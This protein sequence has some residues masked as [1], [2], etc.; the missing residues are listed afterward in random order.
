M[1]KLLGNLKVSLKLTLISVAFVI[2]ILVLLYFLTAEQN[3]RIDFAQKEIYGDEYLRPLKGLMELAPDYKH[4]NHNQSNGTTNSSDAKQVESKIDNLFAE[5]EN[6]ETKL[7]ESLSTKEKLEELKSVWASLK[8]NPGDS[9]KGKEFISGIRGMISYVGDKSNLILDP[10]LDSYYIMD[11][12]LLKLPENMD[13]LYQI[14]TYGNDIVLKGNLTPEEK[15]ELIVKTGLLKSN[16]EALT[17]GVNVAFDNNPAENLKGSLADGLT[18][19][20]NGVNSFLRLVNKKILY[21]DTIAVSSI[22]Y[23]AAAKEALKANFDFWDAAAADLD[24][25]LQARIDG[26]NS[27]KYFTLG[28]VAIVLVLSLGFVFFITKN[29]TTSILTLAN[30]AKQFSEG[31]NNIKVEIDSKDELGMLASVF[32]EMIVKINESIQTVRKEKEDVEKKIEI[33]VKESEEK[34]IYLAESVDTMLKSIERFADGDLSVQLNVLTNDDIGKLYNGFNKAVISIKEL[35]Y[36]LTDTINATTNVASQLSSSTGDLAAGFEEQ[37]NQTSEVA[38][39]ISEMTSTIYDTTKNAN[40]AA[41]AANKAGDFAKEGGTVVKETVEGMNRIAQVVTNASQTVDGLGKSSDQIGE[42]IQVIDDIADQTN[43]LALNAA[44][45]AARAGEQGRG[46][47]VVADEV[48]KLAE[49][50]TK[51]TKEIAGMIKQIQ[52]ETKVAVASIAAGKTEVERGKELAAKA[53]VALQEIIKASDEVLGVINQ[54]AAASEE[55][56][57]AAEQINNNIVNISKVVNDSAMNMN[58]IVKASESLND[59]NINLK[60]LISSFS[61]SKDEVLAA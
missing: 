26:F 54:V 24:E 14:L 29:I 60:E 43:L 13:L 17:T 38:S 56:S 32:N 5:I 20:N 15:T 48:R 36:S 45:E 58:H 34:N 59:L 37:G 55:Q 16:S 31:E 50:T 6:T 51:A 9:E 21:T 44:I 25:L 33:A 2:P 41:K 3:I 39:A 22:E 61:I 10:D 11:A 7:G 47:A 52:Q 57:A 40:N 4:L 8:K 49:R 53:G 27:S 46:F 1:K 19:T 28:S 12:V 30:S 23:E 18:T 35:I 42:I